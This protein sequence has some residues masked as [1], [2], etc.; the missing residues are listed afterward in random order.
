MDKPYGL[1]WINPMYR[2]AKSRRAIF[3]A[4]LTDATSFVF[5]EKRRCAW[6]SNAV[7]VFGQ[8][9]PRHSGWSARFGCWSKHVAS[10]KDCG[11]CSPLT[12]FVSSIGRASQ[13]RSGEVAR[14]RSTGPCKAKRRGWSK[15]CHY[16]PYGPAALDKPNGLHWINPMGCIG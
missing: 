5:V 3:S 1:H 15:R 12:L 4:C 10:V 9:A 16:K 7:V 13:S 8:K 2:F 11:R 14:H 6:L